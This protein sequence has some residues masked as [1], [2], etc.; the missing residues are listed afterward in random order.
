MGLVTRPRRVARNRPATTPS[1]V[2][3][4]RAHTAAEAGARAHARRTDTRPRSA[5]PRRTDARP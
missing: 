4:F 3:L 5:N 1:K 2:N